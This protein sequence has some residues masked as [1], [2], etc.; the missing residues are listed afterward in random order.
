MLETGNNNSAKTIILSIRLTVSG[1][2]FSIE[3]KKPTFLRTDKLD[4][5]EKLLLKNKHLRDINSKVDI[6]IYTDNASLV[7]AKFLEQMTSL[8]CPDNCAR[9]CTQAVDDIYEL[10]LV[11]KN[12]L[13]SLEKLFNNRL[14]YRSSLLKIRSTSKEKI[15]S[16]AMFEQICSIVISEN[17]IMSFSHNLPCPDIASM[18]YYLN[19]LA[20]DSNTKIEI[21]HD[22]SKKLH[23]KLKPYYKSITRKCE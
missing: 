20:N 23:K 3:G 11:P 2:Y 19:T 10:L 21:Y 14:T 9:I 1:L 17:G 8:P 22:S 4:E 15:V 18:L 16:L 12:M 6:T 7:P 5:L 13:T